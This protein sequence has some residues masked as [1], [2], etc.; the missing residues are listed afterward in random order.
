MTRARKH[1][2]SLVSRHGALALSLIASSA[3]VA[4]AAAADG[5]TEAD[6]AEAHPCAEDGD[7]WFDDE[8]YDDDC[9]EG[10][11]EDL[12]EEDPKERDLEEE[13]EAEEE[14]EA[15]SNHD[16][17]A[18]H[19][20]KGADVRTSGRDAPKGKTVAVARGAQTKAAEQPSETT[21]VQ[22]LAPCSTKNSWCGGKR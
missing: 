17:P 4:A 20:K 11:E 10:S 16:T 15:P 18:S 14:K 13:E 5:P 3:P 9:V 7:D 1:Y 19:L 8:Y 22:T 2:S 21:K 6:A 12:E